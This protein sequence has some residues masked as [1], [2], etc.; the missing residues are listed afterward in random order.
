MERGDTDLIREVLDGRTD[1]FGVLVERYQKVIFN[2]AYRMTK[3]YDEAQDITQ[4]AF[5]RAYEHLDRYD[6]RFKFFSWL[7]RIATNE[8]LNRIKSAEK[9]DELN[10]GLNAKEKSPDEICG[11]TEMGRKIQEALMDLD[12]AYRSLIILRHFRDCS[13]REIGDVLDLS[14][15]TVKSRLFTARRLMRAALVSRGILGDE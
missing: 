9:M 13:Y 4:V 10:P 3:D 2:L 8:T 11:E 5:V 12:P 14:E 7:Y 15:K 6:A 1:A